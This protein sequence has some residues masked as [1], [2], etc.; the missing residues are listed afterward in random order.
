MTETT[1]DPSLPLEPKLDASPADPTPPK[2]AKPATSATSD[3]LPSW[4]NN[5]PALTSEVPLPVPP[6]HAQLVQ[7]LKPHVIQ[8]RLILSV[9]GGLMVVMA[10]LLAIGSSKKPVVEKVPVA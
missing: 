5:L 1:S 8:H 9:G 2:S 10:L 6:W 4:V 3:R 7:Q